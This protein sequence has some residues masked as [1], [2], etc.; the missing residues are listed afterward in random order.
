MSDE[1]KKQEQKE[2]K[3]YPDLNQ[4]LEILNEA[5]EW[6]LGR[7]KEQ[8]I[9]YARGFMLAGIIGELNGNAVKV[10]NVIAGFTN[11]FRNTTITNKIIMRYAGMSKTP[12]DN[13]LKELKFY[14]LISSHYLPGGSLTRKIRRI[15]LNRWDTAKSLLIKENKIVVG[16]DNKVTFVIPNP[17]RKK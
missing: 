15:N 14:H 7:K 17:Y 8:F 5:G 9:A 10:L 12:L 16:L 6:V 3:E 1:L 11:K 2:A 4:G 13:A